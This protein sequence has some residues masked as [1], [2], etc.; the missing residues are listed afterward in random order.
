[1]AYDDS[2]FRGESGFRAEPGYHPDDEPATYGAGISGFPPGDYTY[3]PAE[4]GERTDAVSGRGYTQAHLEDV[5]DDPAHGEPGRDRIGV[6]LAWE[7][8][9]LLGVAVVGF[10][11]FRDHR[12][13]V[14]GAGLRNLMISATALGLL[15]LGAGLSLRAASPNLA[16][17][18]IA[19]GSA[20]FFADHAGRGLLVTAVQAGALALV[21]GAVIALLTVGLHVPAWAASLGA[22]VAIA[23]WIQNHHATL[24]LPEGAYQPAPHAGYLFGAFAAASLAA[25]VVGSV[26]PVR[27]WLGRF[28]P[29][30]DPADRRGGAAGAVS[31]A[32][33]LGSSVLAAAAGVLTTLQ[34]G[35][36]EPA[37]TSLTLT[38]L[39]LGG[40]LLGG[41]SAFGRRG[42]LLGTVL[43]T[44]LVTLVVRYLE[45]TDVSVPLLAVGASAIGLG[46]VA[47]RLVE[48]FGR[49]RPM[50]AYQDTSWRP[51]SRTKVVAEPAPGG[52]DGGW[53]GGRPTGWTS[54]LPASSTDDRWGRDEGWGGR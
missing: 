26:K 27:R 50:L 41:T 52:D 48:A 20:L 47:T 54:P 36:V 24:R 35:R 32:A 15:V 3:P 42:G 8:A 34:A 22:G 11:L 40:A 53:S 4:I 17:G 31:V 29:V 45:V 14:T 1:M 44:A 16:V 46:L 7:F 9:L 25:G 43:A 33:L 21:V 49:P 5:F 12:F 10:L 13:A 30:G 38:A 51:E 23:A 6:H 28:R 2:R 19:L 37:D 39:A 18:P